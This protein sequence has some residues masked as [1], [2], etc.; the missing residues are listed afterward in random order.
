M[1]VLGDSFGVGVV[2]HL[3]RKD[4]GCPSASPRNLNATNDNGVPLTTKPP[5]STDTSEGSTPPHD[6]MEYG[7]AS[8]P[9]PPSHGS[10]PQW[11]LSTQESAENPQVYM[12]SVEIHTGSADSSSPQKQQQGSADDEESAL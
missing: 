12:N 1:N 10:T 3:S 9:P 2:Q 7:S 11:S 5:D 4:L 6:T 8:L